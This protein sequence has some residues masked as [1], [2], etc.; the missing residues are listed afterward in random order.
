MNITWKINKKR[1]NW[2]PT[3]IYKIVKE[4]WEVDLAIVQIAMLSTIPRHGGKYSSDK[5]CFHG[6][7]ERKKGWKPEE[8]YELNTPQPDSA[9]YET[10][11]VLCWKPGANPEYPEIKES[12]EKLRHAYEKVLKEAYDSIPFEKSGSLGMSKECKKHIAPGIAA[13]KMLKQGN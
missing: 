12:F 1:G 5:K 11:L 7:G 8:Y 2:R 9:K 3:L 10:S 6:S 4:D 13:K